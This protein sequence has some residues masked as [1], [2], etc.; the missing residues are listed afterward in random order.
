[1]LQLEQ[2]Q[3]AVVRSFWNWKEQADSLLA[4]YEVLSHR[5]FP[6][7]HRK[8]QLDPEARLAHMIAVL[9]QSRQSGDKLTFLERLEAQIAAMDDV[10]VRRVLAAYL[11]EP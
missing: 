7:R 10:E 11:S 9:R 3:D 1:M 6:N 2:V 4:W 5:L 8:I